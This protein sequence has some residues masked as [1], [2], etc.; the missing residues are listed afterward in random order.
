MCLCFFVCVCFVC[1]WVCV[2][3]CVYTLVMYAWYRFNNVFSADWMP[4]V[5]SGDGG[6]RLIQRLG[7]VNGSRHQLS[8]VP[9]RAFVVMKS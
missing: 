3:V 9:A 8:I 5:S 1:L 7:R 4:C 6:V 2:Y